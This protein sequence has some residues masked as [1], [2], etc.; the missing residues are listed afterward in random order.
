MST[1]FKDTKG[2]TWD[3]KI[4]LASAKRIDASNFDLYL[5]EGL[6]GN[7]MSF[8]QPE[9]EFLRLLFA[10]DALMFAVIWAIIQPQVNEQ[11][12]GF[13][14]EKGVEKWDPTVAAQSEL[15]DLVEMEFCEGIDGP[16]K[17]EARDAFLE[18]ASDFFHD[19]KTA[20]LMLKNEYRRVQEK[21]EQ[22]MA[23]L[24][25][26]LQGLIDEEYQ[27]SLQKLRSELSAKRERRGETSKQ[28]SARSE[29]LNPS[30]QT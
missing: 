5:P 9:R 30:G 13:L 18:A 11:M 12:R 1:V 21:M 22:D 29:F 26:E 15:Y 14:T 28:S 24:M 25:P 3:V 4:N 23:T 16:V 10:S 17:K 6:Q 7:K 8:L 20:L 2:R 27:L 19:Q